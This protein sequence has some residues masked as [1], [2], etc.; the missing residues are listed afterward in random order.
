MSNAHPE[1]NST[2][3]GEERNKIKRERFSA[4]N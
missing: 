4:N 3:E 2:L 1:G